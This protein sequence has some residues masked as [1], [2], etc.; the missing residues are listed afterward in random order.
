[1]TCI[2]GMTYRVGGEGLIRRSASRSPSTGCIFS[3]FLRLI[4]QKSTILQR[5][6]AGDCLTRL[7]G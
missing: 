2:T 4:E 3:S 1:M 7:V 6:V 5:S